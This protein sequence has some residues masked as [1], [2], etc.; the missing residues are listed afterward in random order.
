MNVSLRDINELSLSLLRNLC[1]LFSFFYSD[2]SDC[3]SKTSSSRSESTCFGN[4]KSSKNNFNEI[5]SSLHSSSAIQSKNT[6][7]NQAWSY[8]NQS[9]RISAWGEVYAH[10]SITRVVFICA[11]DSRH[12]NRMV[13]G[14][15]RYSSREFSAGFSFAM[16]RASS[17]NNLLWLL[18][19]AS[20]STV[21]SWF[22]WQPWRYSPTGTD[23]LWCSASLVEIS[24]RLADIAGITSR[25]DNFVN[26]PTYEFLRNWGLERWQGCLKFSCLANYWGRSYFS[27]FGRQLIR[28]SA[29][30]LSRKQI[31]SW[32]RFL[33]LQWGVW[34][35]RSLL[36]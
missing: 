24:Y 19:A 31:T 14:R 20:T 6:Q 4:K 10:N 21:Q 12:H 22:P 18:L 32:T 26:N 28:W 5:I 8:S 17:V 36:R 3:S 1:Y 34:L 27:E 23:F 7:K 2:Q 15:C 11:R 9:L 13:S 16:W 29:S 33:L 25:T 30:V 35:W